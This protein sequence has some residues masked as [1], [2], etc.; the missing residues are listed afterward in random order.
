VKYIY[1]DVYEYISILIMKVDYH[2]NG[3]SW[4]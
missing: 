3:L 4:K 2:K 1:I